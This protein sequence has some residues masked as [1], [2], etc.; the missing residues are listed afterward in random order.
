MKRLTCDLRP[1]SCVLWAV[2][3]CLLFWLTAQPGAW[4]VPGDIAGSGT[5]EPDGFVGI[6]DLNRILG[7]NWNGTCDPGDWT[8]GDID[9]DGEVGIDDLNIVLGHWSH[10]DPDPFLGT[11]LAPI[12]YWN[13]S[14]AFVDVMK[15]GRP[16]L[17]TNPNGQPFDT[18]QEVETDTNGWPILQSGEA[19]QTH[20]F[21]NG[22]YPTGQYICTFDGAGTLAFEWDAQNAQLVSQGRMTFDVTTATNQGFLMRIVSSDPMDHVRNIKIWMPGFENATSSFHPLFLSRLQ[23][24]KVLRFM[25]WQKINGSNEIDW[26]TDR[27]KPTHAFQNDDAGGVALEYIIELCND[28]NADPWFCMPHQADDNYVTQ[29]AQY[30]KDNLEDPDATIYVEYSN[31]LW[32]DRFSQYFWLDPVPRSDNWFNKWA[33][34]S[35]NDFQIWKTV[36]KDTP[37]ADPRSIV[38]VVAGQ[39]DNDWIIENVLDKNGMIDP[40]DPTGNEVLFDAVSCSTYLSGS[41]DGFDPAAPTPEVA[42]DGILFHTIHRTIPLFDTSDP[43][44][45]NPPANP[46][47]NTQFYLDHKVWVDHYTTQTGRA[48]SLISYEGGQH[49]VRTNDNGQV[50]D[51]VLKALQRRPLI[52][53]AY[54]DNIAAFKQSGGSLYMAY[55][56]VGR[57]SDQDSF[58]HFE[59][60]NES[61]NNAPKHRAVIGGGGR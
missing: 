26:D 6:D 61:I 58:G 7:I 29:F 42:A 50:S 10:T 45:P 35:G 31:E 39:K 25:D 55:H 5:D 3:V 1:A 17:S 33:D 36:F 54:V 53:K 8:Q 48:I 4:A 34:E 60:Q 13:T 12:A 51:E 11:N 27:K 2:G 32:N 38:R 41:T 52:Y 59:F 28:L 16:W 22:G 40:A 21:D 57:Y 46:K 24:F 9:G 15:Q 49:Y 19:A 18:G 47:N 30:V 43:F 14:W 56:T 37:P 23:A 20:F 44:D